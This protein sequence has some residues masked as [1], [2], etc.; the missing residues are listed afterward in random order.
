MGLA[1]TTH[2]T[3]VFRISFLFVFLWGPLVEVVGI[4]S[5]LRARGL[6]PVKYIMG[7]VQSL[8]HEKSLITWG[9]KMDTITITIT[10]TINFGIHICNNYNK[11]NS[12]N[13]NFSFRGVLQNQQSFKPFSLSQFWPPMQELNHAEQLTLVVKVFLYLFLQNNIHSWRFVL[14]LSTSYYNYISSWSDFGIHVCRWV[15]VDCDIQII[16]LHGKIRA[17]V[18]YWKL[19]RMQEVHWYNYSLGI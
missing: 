13:D 18:R 7:N 8:I 1:L 4:L 5:Q 15:I 6:S 16:T 10:I 3:L 12:L 9:V 14:P 2:S 17:I 19:P 11:P